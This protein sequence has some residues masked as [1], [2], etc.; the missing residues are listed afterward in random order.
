M[1]VGDTFFLAMSAK[2]VLINLGRFGK[3]KTVRAENRKCFKLEVIAYFE[4]VKQ[5]SETW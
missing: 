2:D 1:V 3:L 5:N 4:C